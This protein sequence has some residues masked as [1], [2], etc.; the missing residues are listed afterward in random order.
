MGL[1]LISYLYKKQGFSPPLAIIFPSVLENTNFQLI[2]SKGFQDVLPQA[3]R[4]VCVVLE[5]KKKKLNIYVK[6]ESLFVE[7]LQIKAR[8][9]LEHFG[10]K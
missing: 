10:R 1:S 4:S 3:R 8:T 9:I 2:I 6:A 7:E 5:M